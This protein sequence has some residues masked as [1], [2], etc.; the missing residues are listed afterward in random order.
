FGGN[1]AKTLNRFDKV[2]AVFG[3]VL[4]V[5]TEGHKDGDAIF[6]GGEIA[7]EVMADFAAQVHAVDP[8][9]VADHAFFDVNHLRFVGGA[10]ATR[11][12]SWSL[13]MRQVG[14]H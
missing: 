5:S 12:H 6:D 2:G 14:G 7:C 3:V 9:L 11:D 8:H 1:H 10:V 13:Q 4:L